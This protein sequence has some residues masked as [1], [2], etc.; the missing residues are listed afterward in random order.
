[1]VG[2][3]MKWKGFVPKFRT[4]VGYVEKATYSFIDTVLP[5]AGKLRFWTTWRIPL[6]QVT[7]PPPCV[8]VGHGRSQHGIPNFSSFMIF[9]IFF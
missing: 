9:P 3:V 2:N 4:Q 6:V 1:M 7:N 5:I 8:F